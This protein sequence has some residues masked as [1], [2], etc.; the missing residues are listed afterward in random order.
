VDTRLLQAALHGSLSDW[1]RPR[2][3][4]RALC[5][6]VLRYPR[7][8]IQALLTVAKEELRRLKAGPAGLSLL[9]TAAASVTAASDSSSRGA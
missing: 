8:Q 2:G 6:R 3:H 9:Q 1:V 4:P 7:P 5:W